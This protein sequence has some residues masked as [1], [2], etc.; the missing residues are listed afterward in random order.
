MG[1]KMIS[2]EALSGF[3]VGEGCFYVESGKDDKYRLGWRIRPAFCVEVRHD[4]REI[5]E[6]LKTALQ[7]GNIYDLDFGRYKGYENKGWRPH[8]KY[9]VSNINDIKTKVI[10]FFQKNLLFGRKQRCFDLFCGIV[11]EMEKRNHLDEI[12]LER[13]KTLVKQLNN[14]N[15]K[16]V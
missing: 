16:G 15:K 2:P 3:V 12:G 13:I 6:M 9:R 11:E 7:C 5:L 10:P 1:S 4:D 8:V 14:L